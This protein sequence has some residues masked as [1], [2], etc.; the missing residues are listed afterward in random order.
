MAQKHDIREEFFRKGRNISQI[1]RD[2]GYDRKTIREMLR[3]DDW[4][5]PKTLESVKGKYFQKLKPYT[6][7]IDSW[8]AADKRERKKQRHTAKRIFDRLSVEEGTRSSFDCSY[9]TVAAYVKEKKRELYGSET[10]C[11]LPLVHKPGEAQSDFGTTAYYENGKRVDEGKYLNLSFPQSNQGFVQLFPGENAECLLE[12]LVNI[13][14][15]I[16]G[17]PPEIWFDNMSTAVTAILKGGDRELTEKFE[18]FKTHYGFKAVFCNADSGHE[19]GNVEGKVGYHRRNMFVPVPRFKSL[20]EYN[21]RLLKDCDKDGHREHYRL[22]TEISKLFEEDRQQLLPL[23]ANEFDTAGFFRVRTNKYAIFSL[24]KGN[25]EYST[26]PKHAAQDVL[27]RLSA[28]EVTV[29]D[30]SYRAVVIHKRLYGKQKQRSMEWIPY[31]EQLSKRP[32]AVKYSGIYE[33]LPPN[34]KT[35]LSKA[36]GGSIGEIIS[37]LARITKQTGWE[38]A[39]ATV[40]NAVEN[41]VNDPDSLHAL[42]RRLHMNLPELPPLDQA[43]GIPM[44]VKWVPDLTVYDAAALGRRQV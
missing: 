35:F 18:R 39:V 38:S 19:K 15:H 21:E 31:L 27:V 17:V 13:F 28:T 5:V 6:E 20:G 40:G 2:S 37:M 36:D 8:L 11:F 26:S 30:E 34:V 32:R 25:H 12:G 10:D 42:H 9:R 24:E 1:S 22:E 44:I 29:L 14:N 4:N 23:P 43:A 16:G 41:S 3:C 33:M 7:I